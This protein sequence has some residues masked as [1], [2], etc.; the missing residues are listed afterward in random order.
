MYV[1]P[2][3]GY[4]APSPSASAPHSDIRPILRGLNGQPYNKKVHQCTI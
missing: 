2:K 1:V 3:A 4:P